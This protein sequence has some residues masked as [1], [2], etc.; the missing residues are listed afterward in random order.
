MNRNARC[1]PGDLA[2]VIGEEP[3]Y[4][5]NLGRLVKVSGPPAMTTD[6]GLTWLVV[7]VA[8]TPYAVMERNGKKRRFRVRLHHRVEHPDTWLLPIRDAKDEMGG[9]KMQNEIDLS[10]QKIGAIRSP[11]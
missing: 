7:P 10:L 1:R 5:E 4:E 11:A 2:L 9:S 6:L 8:D 3:G